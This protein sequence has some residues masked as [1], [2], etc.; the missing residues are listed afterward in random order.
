MVHILIDFLFLLGCGLDLVETLD[1]R[2][3]ALGA[4]EEFKIANVVLVGC[5]LLL[6]GACLLGH[7]GWVHLS[8][9]EL[10]NDLGDVRVISLTSELENLIDVL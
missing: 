7:H 3:E 4:W 10:V 1:L 5:L 6:A 9:L 8:V 2:A